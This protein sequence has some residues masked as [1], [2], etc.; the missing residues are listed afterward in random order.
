M[1][2]TTT[3]DQIGMSI[4]KPDEEQLAKE[5]IE[6]PSFQ[7]EKSIVQTCFSRLDL[8][9]KQL[10]MVQDIL[11]SRVETYENYVYYTKMQPYCMHYRAYLSVQFSLLPGCAPCQDLCKQEREPPC[12]MYRQLPAYTSTTVSNYNEDKFC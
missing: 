8:Y 2:I 5:T 10:S 3:M 6:W 12:S 7:N 9:L 4:V 1:E 11:V